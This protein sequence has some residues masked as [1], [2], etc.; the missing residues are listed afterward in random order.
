M[1]SIRLINYSCTIRKSNFSNFSEYSS[2][3]SF[4]ILNSMGFSTD[5]LITSQTLPQYLYTFSLL[6]I[7]RLCCYH[8]ML[9]STTSYCYQ[10]HS[11]FLG[12]VLD[13]SIQVSNHLHT[14]IPMVSS[15]LF[16]QIVIDSRLFTTIFLFGKPHPILLGFSEVDKLCTTL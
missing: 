12:S 9:R 16:H 5:L 4:L 11:A 10:V 2:K 1:L 13:S 3:Q 8:L 15:V 6:Y 14:I 7:H